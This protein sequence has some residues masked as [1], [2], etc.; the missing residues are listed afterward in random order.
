MEEFRKY[1]HIE[2]FGTAEV[3]GIEIGECYIFP[4][5]DGTNGVVWDNSDDDIDPDWALYCASRKRVLS[6]DKDNA[7]FYEYLHEKNCENRFRVLFRAYP[8]W[9]LYGEWLVPHS[10]KT[11]RDDAWEKFYIFDVY[12]TDDGKYLPYGQYKTILEGH[13]L[14]YVPPL[15][16]MKNATYEALVKELG[17]NGY[18]IRDGEGVGE[19]IVIKNYNFVNKYGRTVWAKLV[20]NEFKEKHSKSQ[21]TDKLM[22]KIVE[23]EIINQYITKHL[24][25]KVVDKIVVVEDG[26]KSEFIPRLLSTVFYDLIREEMW[27]ILKKFKS[28][29]I[30]FKTLRHLVV[31]K[32]KEL[33]PELF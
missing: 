31:N 1:M 21:V 33:R 28:P 6:S 3:D 19:G 9:V 10:L 18:L 14:E 24:V 15:C 25:D 20:T 32:V 2:R 26:W 13:G 17:N 4:K 12:D 16:T 11:Y 8:Y 7:G 23:E 30:D 5:L 27:D 22:K 29:K